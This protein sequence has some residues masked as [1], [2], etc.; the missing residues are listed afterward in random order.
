MFLILMKVFLVNDY[1]KKLF[2]ILT[3]LIFTLS[4]A[5]CSNKSSNEQEK[6]PAVEQNTVEDKTSDEG[7]VV[8]DDSNEIPEESVEFEE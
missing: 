5:G 1:M 6:E 8:I 2:L 4:F 3:F 7:E